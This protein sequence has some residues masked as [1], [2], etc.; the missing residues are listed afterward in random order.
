MKKVKA[1]AKVAPLHRAGLPLLCV[2]MLWIAPQLA[3][4]DA[5][6]SG[7]GPIAEGVYVGDV[8]LAS[9]SA[10]A[11]PGQIVLDWETEIEVNNAGFNLYRVQEHTYQLIKLNGALIASQAS[12]GQG[13]AAYEFVDTF[14]VPG[15][16][17]DY[18]LEGVDM[19]GFPT[20]LGTITAQV[21]AEG[22]VGFRAFLPMVSK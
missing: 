3:G 1:Q 14:G 18:L 21:P 2:A 16:R 7:G 10:T 15:S 17:Y 22:Q 13:G 12:G 8:V 20:Y 19:Q 4:A 6:R 5:A 9:F 11:A